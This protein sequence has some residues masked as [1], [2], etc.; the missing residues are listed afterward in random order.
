MAIAPRADSLLLVT[1]LESLRRQHIKELRRALAGAPI[2]VIGFAVAGAE[3]EPGYGYAPY[4]YQP[5]DQRKK[6]EE[7]AVEAEL[8]S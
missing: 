8:R 7:D 1:R 3:T 6:L 4:D 5:Y 2:S